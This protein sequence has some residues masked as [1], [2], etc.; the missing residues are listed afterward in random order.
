MIRKKIDSVKI[1]LT[2]LIFSFGSLMGNAQSSPL[3]E[4]WNKTFGG[5][6]NERARSVQQTM[7]GGYIF[8][9]ETSSYGAGKSDVWPVNVAQPSIPTQTPTPTAIPTEAQMVSPTE[10]ATGFEVV[11]AMT[12][13]LIAFIIRRKRSI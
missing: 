9:G 12:I 1:L 7:D 6:N 8:A 11:P 4:Q 3:S 2:L 10:K 13:L 5:A